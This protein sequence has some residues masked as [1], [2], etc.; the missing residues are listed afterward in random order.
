MTPLSLYTRPMHRAPR[1]TFITPLPYGY[2]V[3]EQTGSEVTLRQFFTWLGVENYLGVHVG[4][5]IARGM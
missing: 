4:M 5:Q 3:V 2:A 1:E